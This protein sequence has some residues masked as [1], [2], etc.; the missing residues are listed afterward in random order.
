MLVPTENGP[1][2]SHII[3]SSWS[4][5]PCTLFVLNA[6]PSALEHLVPPEDL[7][8]RQNSIP[9]SCPQQ[10]HCF[11][12]RFAGFHAELNRVTLLQTPLHF[13]PWKDIKIT[14]H[15]ANLPTATKA[16]NQLRKVKL[17]PGFPLHLP[18]PPLSFRGPFALR[19]K[20]I[21]INF[22]TDHVCY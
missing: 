4:W 15:F 13:R 12:T 9:I 17:H 7:G 10:L 8:W 20:N 2:M 14:T 6:L 1:H 11:G 3:L 19:K 5:T 21:L 22:W 16:Q 18:Q